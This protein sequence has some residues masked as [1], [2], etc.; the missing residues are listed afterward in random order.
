MKLI[1]INLIFF[2]LFLLFFDQSTYCQDYTSESKKAIKHYEKGLFAFENNDLKLAVEYAYEALEKDSNFVEVYLLLGEIAYNLGNKSKEIEYFSKV[3]EK[4]SVNF[5]LTYYLLALTYMETEKYKN[6]IPYFTKFLSFNIDNQTYNQSCIFNIEVCKFRTNALQNPVPFNPVKLENTI[7]T[8]FDEYFPSISA[9]GKI[10]IFTRLLPTYGNNPAVGDYHEDIYISK[11]NENLTWTVASTIGNQIN[12]FSNQGAHTISAD[13]SL[14]IY[15]DCTCDD[16]LVK[17]CDLYLS[18]YADNLW[19]K[20]VKLG[21]PINTAYWEAQPCI[22]SD[23]K[24]IYFV[25]NRQGGKGM[26]D[27]WKIIKWADGTWSGAINLGDSIN[28]E[29][30]EMSPFIHADNKTFY[31][32]SDGFPGMGGLDL[33]R[34]EIQSDKKFSTPQNLGYPINSFEN[35]FR[36]IL[37]AK[38]ETAYYSS[39]RDTSTGQDIYKF[40]LYPEMQPVKTI[41]VKGNIYD[42]NSKEIITANYEIFNLNTTDKVNYDGDVN[43]FFICLPIEENYALN[44]S[45]TGYLFYSENFSLTDLPDSIDYYLLDIPLIPIQI[46]GKIILKNIFFDTDSFNL[47]PESFVELNKLIEFLNQ[48]PKLN[49]EIGGH[50]DNIGTEKYNLI[51]SNNRAKAVVDYLIKNGVNINRL[52]YKGYGFSEPI[53]DNLT[54]KSRAQNRRTEFKIIK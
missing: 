18:E 21:N 51:L 47:K 12:N 48:N 23:G 37:D 54:E 7:N 43:K 28:T 45:K 5:P 38:G 33:F 40:E 20:G 50:T 2:L 49:I 11:L 42:L 1:K 8:E 31:F 32:S 41:Y 14:M 26:K 35:E 27:I 19:S 22:S 53:T 36:I 6:A 17:C 16:G 15:T 46:G 13:G 24:T 4:D 3:I 10:L 30:N 25:S 39:N 44:V 29:G 34:S 9:D 52:T